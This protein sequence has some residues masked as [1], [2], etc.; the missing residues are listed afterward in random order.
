MGDQQHAEVSGCELDEP[1]L[2]PS[3]VALL[4]SPH[5][6]CF[7]LQFT[8]MSAALRG[9]NMPESRFAGPPLPRSLPLAR[10]VELAPVHRRRAL[11]QAMVVLLALRLSH[12]ATSV[13]SIRC[14]TLGMVQRVAARRAAVTPEGVVELG[15]RLYAEAQYA[16]AA[17]EWQRAANMGYTYAH[18]LL[19]NLMIDGRPGLPHDHERAYLLAAAGAAM[20][21]PHCKGVLG[22][23]YS[24]NYGVEQNLEKALELAQTSAAAGSQFGLFVLGVCYENGEGVVADKAKAAHLWRLA[25]EQGH[26]AAQ[27][28]LGVM[29]KKGDAVGPSAAEAV[30]LWQQATSQGHAPAQTNLAHLFYCGDGVDTDKVEAV[31]LWRLAAEQG[32]SIAQFNLAVMLLTGDGV[33]QDVGEA[34]RW[35][36]SAALQGHRNATIELG[37]MRLLVRES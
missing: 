3:P 2:A 6:R 24:G 1:A 17:D 36:R 4:Q 18:A 15:H 13:K 23:C 12:R 7:I 22:R 37:R 28:N 8:S 11:G 5:Y 35:M 21:C 33:A 32:R 25:A 16:C 27:F 29:F 26:A 14:A 20:H 31:R 34:V 30:R 10:G 19:S 9:L